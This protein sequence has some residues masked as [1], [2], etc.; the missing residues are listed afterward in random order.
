MKAAKYEG[1]GQ[2]KLLDIPKPTPQKGEALVKVKYSG[3]CGSDLEAYKTG[4]Y[5]MKLVLGHEITGSI[6]ELG[7]EVKNWEINDR[8]TINPGICCGKCHFCQIGHENLCIYEDSIGIGQ[9]G[10]HA[11]YVLVKEEN[12]VPLPDNIPDRHGTVFDQIATA[13]LAL[14]ESN[15]IPGTYCVILGMGTMGQFLLQ[16]LKIAGARA[17]AVVEKN[18]YR[19]EVAKKFNPNL[20]LS[21]MALAKIKRFPKR[22]FGGVDFVFECSG[23]PILVNNA[24][25]ILRKGGTVV[26]VGI[27]DKPVEI[28]LLKYVMNQIRIQGAWSYTIKDFEYAVEL[29]AKKMIDPEPI[30]TK[31]ISLDDIVEE[32]FEC[33]IDPETKDIKILVEP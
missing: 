12:L 31:I 13:P 24:I 23:V 15:F 27:W 29:V 18:P 11:E 1:K 10:G 14:R 20:A 26:Q 6:T 22:S 2:I 33:A 21:K 16:Y 28:N 9:N 5:P 7:P 4:L 30:V 25:D 8:V 17:V 3:I 32:G 19:L